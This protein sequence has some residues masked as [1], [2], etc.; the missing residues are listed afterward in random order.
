MQTAERQFMRVLRKAE[1]NPVVFR[2]S[3]NDPSILPE[4]KKLIRAAVIMNAVDGGEGSGNPNHDPENG[5]FTS[6]SGGSD[7]TEEYK[8]NAKPG[9][10]KIEFEPGYRVSER[11]EEI[12]VAQWVHK[13]FGGDITLL[14]ESTQE[15]VKKPDYQWNGL[16]WELKNLDAGTDNAVQKNIRKALH[17]IKSNPGGIFLDISKSGIDL[18][19]A[20]K[21]I[22]TRMLKSAG[23][24]ADV[25][26]LYDKGKYSVMRFDV[27]EKDQPETD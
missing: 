3:I 24:S 7:V 21:S 12:R 26:I 6:G 9:I 5:R 14:K 15:N 11:K 1:R 13:T 2:D 10:G 8:R 16:L 25:M 19:S 18:S 22:T 20:K 23:F 27:K 17:Q 4:T